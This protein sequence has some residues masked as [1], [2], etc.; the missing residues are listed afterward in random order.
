MKFKIMGKKGDAAFDYD[1]IEMQKL[2]FNELIND[3]MLPMVIEDG[4]NRIL[5]NFDPNIDEKK[6]NKKLPECAIW[7]LRE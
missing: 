2:K 7:N 4:K 6:F 1:T 3:N 5:E